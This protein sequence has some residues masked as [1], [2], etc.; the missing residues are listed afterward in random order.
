MKFRKL[1]FIV[2][3]LLACALS[4]ER[5]ARADAMAIDTLPGNV[6]SYYELCL[7]Y[8]IGCADAGGGAPTTIMGWRYAYTNASGGP[9]TDGFIQGTEA[10]IESEVQWLTGTDPDLK[11]FV[12]RLKALGVNSGPVMKAF[13]QA[14]MHPGEAFEYTLQQQ[15]G[16]TIV[17]KF[18]ISNGVRSFFVKI[19]DTVVLLGDV[20]DRFLRVGLFMVSPAATCAEAQNNPEYD[21]Y[22]EVFCRDLH[23]T[24]STSGGGDG[25]GE[26]GEV[27]GDGYTDGA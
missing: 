27:G 19:G 23:Y 15:D 20:F 22:L 11:E 1:P 25:G 9:I 16:K 8:G 12:S 6:Y 24:G 2:P 7:Y 17:I 14:I 13:F 10:S 3:I 21:Y 5:P 26:G 4:F 18:V